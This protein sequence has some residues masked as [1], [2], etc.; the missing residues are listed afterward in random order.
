MLDTKLERDILLDSLTLEVSSDL[1]EQR[2]NYIF[3]AGHSLATITK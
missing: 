2:N 1:Q 3:V